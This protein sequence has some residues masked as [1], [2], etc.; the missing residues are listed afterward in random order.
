[1][2][3]HLEHIGTKRHSGRY[4]W[5]SGGTPYQRNKGLVTYYNEMKRSGMTDKQIAEGLGFTIN[6][7]RA[8]KTIASS[9]VRAM[10]VAQA[11]RLKD[12][13][14]SYSAIGRAMDRNESSVR[15]LLNPKTK[16]KKEQ[17]Y[18]TA[19][20]LK[21]ELESKDY[22]DIGVGVERYMGISRT[23]LKTAVAMLEEEG[24]T[25]HY[26]PVQQ[27]GTGK[28]TSVMVLAK[29]DVTWSEVNKNREGIAQVGSY[30][31]DGGTSVLGYEPIRS[32]SSK[33]LDIRYHEDGGSEKDGV[34]ELR[35]GVDDISLG[36]AKYAQ[37]RIGVDDKHYLKGMAVYTDDLPDGVDLR[38]NTNKAKGTPLAK[39]L[40]SMKTVDG[41]A[42]GEIDNDNPFGSTVKQRH[43]LDKNGEKQLSAINM[44]YEEGKW[45]EWSRNLSSQVLSKQSPALAKKQ[46]DLAYDTKK[47]EYDEIM[48]LTNPVVKKKLLETFGDD[49]DSAAVHLKAAALPR[50]GTHVIMPFPKMKDTEIYA[51][52]YTDGETV[53]LVR[54]PHGGTFEIPQL[55]VNN[56][57]RI[58][59][60][61]LGSQTPDAVGI[62]AKVAERLS[63]ADFDGD[64]VL[65]IPNP[66][67]K[68]IKTTSPL[69]GLIDFDPKTA[70]PL[71]D[72]A[73]KMKASTK[74]TEM[75]KISNL[76]ADMT[77]KGAPHN[78]IAAAVRH[79]MVVIDAEKHH[80]NY[81]LSAKENGIAELKTRYQGGPTAGASTLIS[82]ASSEARPLNRKEGELRTDPKTGKTKR[83]YVDPKTGEK[84]YTETGDSYIKKTKRKDGSVKETEIFKTTKST[85]MYEE[86]DAFNLSSGTPMEAVYAT[87]AN[88]LKALGNTTRKAAIKATTEI[89]KA[90]PEATKKYAKEVDSLRAKLNIAL[91]NAPLERQAQLLANTT[92]AA[93]KAENPHM[94]ADDIKKVKGQALAE[95]R[96][97]TGAGKQRIKIE[98]KEWEAIQADAISPTR[99]KSILNNTDLDVVKHLATP[100]VTTGM[101]GA[102]EA[103]ARNMLANGYTQ[104]DI[105]SALGVSTNAINDLA[106]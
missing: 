5:G 17:L 32:V 93:K 28:N 29:P 99:L 3:D 44:V 20:A 4:P 38:F 70:Y 100:R 46:L 51:P 31:Y 69:K 95:A 59:K 56:R 78:E 30:T 94:D 67:G 40:K 47:V 6:E 101:S 75:G 63:G 81:K 83:V 68:I 104:A 48:S 53:V 26:I 90:D 91:K 77:V 57:S 34:I 79:S 82:R 42:D 73:P 87:H 7:L 27:L 72:D 60:K 43:Y 92:V 37:V 9:E 86:S 96:V 76:I 10:D 71:P 13:G 2:K 21:D 55:T 89:R 98:P 54:Y 8:K 64:T 15:S 23:K 80:L 97:R 103:R 19:N 24:Y 106:N 16:A 102:N 33:R 58:A 74:Q 36:R 18:N 11:T 65:V 85:K 12:K 41:E 62:N 52:N 45:G 39:T 35:R 66:G 50:Q 1:M 84:L 105:A 14:Y 49:V 61:A 25:T 88:K 22:L